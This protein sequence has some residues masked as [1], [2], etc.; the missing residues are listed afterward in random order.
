M[1]YIHRSGFAFAEFST[2]KDAAKALQAM[3]GMELR[4]R[5]LAVNYS[6]SNPH[7]S[8]GAYVDPGIKSAD[9]SKRCRDSEISNLQFKRTTIRE[10]DDKIRKIQDAL[11]QS[12][13][14]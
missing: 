2:E 11:I 3:S 6:D 7:V 14:L 12:E 9:S 8:S 13:K 10:L 1:Q 4:G 5:K